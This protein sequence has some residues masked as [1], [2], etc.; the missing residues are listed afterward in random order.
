MDQKADQIR[1]YNSL[2]SLLLRAFRSQIG[3]D[4][5]E[6][7]WGEIQTVLCVVMRLPGPLERICLTESF[8]ANGGGG[9]YQIA[10][11]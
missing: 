11:G 9:N 6:V 1:N 3:T 7:R 10:S 2:S 8:L 5:G 4:L